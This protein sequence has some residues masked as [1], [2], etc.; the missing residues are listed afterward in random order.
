M[1]RM[2]CTEYSTLFGFNKKLDQRLRS[3]YWLFKY[4]DQIQNYHWTRYASFSTTLQ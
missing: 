3:F 2:Q 1:N 4:Q